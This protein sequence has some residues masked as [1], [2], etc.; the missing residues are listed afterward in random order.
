MPYKAVSCFLLKGEDRENNK[1]II[2]RPNLIQTTFNH[3]QSLIQKGNS[4]KRI[5]F[6]FLQFPGR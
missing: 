6:L 2:F 5:F 1:V 4:P 3:S